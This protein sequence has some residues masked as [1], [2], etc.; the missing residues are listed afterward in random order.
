MKISLIT[1]AKKHTKNGNR[2]SIV[3]WAKFLRGYG[4]NTQ[5]NTEYDG[6]NCDIM[7]A[8]HAW[9][10]A[11][12]IN[13]YKSK[14]PKGPL[15]VALGGTDVNTFL[16]TDPNVTLL[17]MEK[18]DALV[19]LHDQIGEALPQHLKKKLHVIFQSAIPLKPVSYTHLTLPTK[20]IV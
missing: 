9:R 17:A 14:Y 12:A 6:S 2:T 10:S 19:G 20:R 3:R 18:A 1:P 7:I 11:D 13:L 4:H 8:L 15:I 16:K 5:I